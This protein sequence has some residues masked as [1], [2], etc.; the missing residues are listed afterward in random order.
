MLAAL[1]VVREVG[2]SR[3]V[4]TLGFCV[5]GTLLACALAVLA[6][7]RD[8]SVESATFLTT[9][10]DFEDPGE[11]GVYISRELLEARKPSLMSGQRVHG[12]ELAG[13][14]ASLRANDLVWN[15]VVG[16]YLKG[17]TPPAFDLLYWNGDSANL[18]GP[19]YAYYLENLYLANRLREPGALTM[20]GES[21]DLTRVT[22]PAYVLATRDDHIVPWRSAYRTTGAR[23]RGRDV[24]ARRV[25]PHRRRGQPAGDES[26]QLLDQRA[27]AP[28]T[29]TTGSSARSRSPGSWWPHWIAVAGAARRPAEAGAPACRQRRLAAARAGARNLRSGALL[30]GAFRANIPGRG[31]RR[32]FR[33]L[34]P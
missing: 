6:A 7:R 33:A 23:R 16:N 8:R 26:T 15:Y 14:F 22:M 19:M 1:D 25:G 13:A 4:N 3:T 10:L 18:P 28:T 11:I 21:I 20:A 30:S 17:E 32:P 5:G 24:R 2:D 27:A 34:R 9:M 29:P 31:P 12:S